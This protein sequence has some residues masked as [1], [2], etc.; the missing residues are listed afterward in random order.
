[1][2]LPIE[3]LTDS[4]F[5]STEARATII[6]SAKPILIPKIITIENVLMVLR[7]AFRI[8]LDTVFTDSNLSYYVA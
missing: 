6:A 2:V 3:D 1:M 8:P 5:W 4:I 7:N